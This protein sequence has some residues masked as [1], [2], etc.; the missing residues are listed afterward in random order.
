MVEKRTETVT[1]CERQGASCC[2]RVLKAAPVAGPGVHRGRSPISTHQ[3]PGGLMPLSA[4][5][6]THPPRPSRASC[7]S[8]A[9]RPGTL[10]S[11]ASHR[12]PIPCA[13]AFAPWIALTALIALAVGCAGSRGGPGAACPPC[14][15]ACA[16]GGPCAEHCD[17]KG[18][19]VTGAPGKNGT[20]HTNEAPACDGERCDG[21]CLCAPGS[22]C[23]YARACV[24]AQDCTDTCKSTGRA[25]GEVC[26]ESC[27]GC[28][29]GKACVSGTCV[30][31]VSCAD[32]VLS[33]RLL[34]RQGPRVGVAVEYS[35]T[36]EMVQARVADLRVRVS[37]AEADLIEAKAGQAL[38]AAGKS[39]Y[40]DER[41]G[42][43]WQRRADGTF[44][45]LAFGFANTQPIR[46]GRLATL[47]FYSESPAAL[48]ISLERRTQV[49]APGGADGAV[50]ST[51][52]HQ[53]LE[54]KP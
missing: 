43:R 40:E 32:C 9:S 35:P 6:S 19:G 47:T 18:D 12:A 45:L 10:S 11:R 15:T 37:G 48:S 17:C 7:A 20:A 8:R 42:K 13:V 4:K 5:L 25:C 33:L 2:L 16:Q 23:N 41:T 1:A 49:L 51:A 3:S 22:A 30:E 28:G 50:Q 21:G 52:Y 39:L 54:V 27:G 14:E 24:P 26:G 36:P 29:T 44:Q 53:P 34:G 38:E 46:A 31:A